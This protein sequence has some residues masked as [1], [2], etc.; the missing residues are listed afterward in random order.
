MCE[1]WV[2]RCVK[3]MRLNSLSLKVL[4]AY[5]AGTVLS[6]ALLVIAAVV[7]LQGN[8]L[9]RMDV[10]A[11]MD[12]T[13]QKNLLAQMDLADLA[14]GM[15]RRVRFDAAGPVGLEADEDSLAWVYDSLR[16]EA[17][18]RVLDDS[19]KTVLLSKAGEAFWPATDGRPHPARGR[20]DFEHDGLTIYG[21]TE[22]IE[23]G[24]RTWYLQVAASKRLMTLLHR[25]ALPLVGTGITLFSLVLL[26]TFG[27]CAYITLRYTLKPLR[28]VS[29]SAAAISPRSMHARLKTEG[30]PLEIA[31]L[32]DSFNRALARLE[33]GYR[34]QQEF[35]GNAAHEL[36]TPLALIRAQ[37]E[38]G[39]V[40]KDRDALLSD[41]E[42]MT[43]QVQQLLLLAEA[44]EA[45]NY[46]FTRVRMQEIADEAVTYL[47]RM[48]EAADVRLIVSGV[49]SD[50]SWK[51]DR[52][53]LFTLLKNLL[54]NAIQHAP[55]QTVVSVGIGRDELSVWDL[56]PGVDAAQLPLL[57]ERFW[58]GAHRR[59]RGAGLG[60]A[61]CQEIALTHGWRLSAERAEPG[62]RFRLQRGEDGQA[63]PLR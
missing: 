7:M 45:H 49:A 25:V 39:D 60:L 36:K 8:L 56:G 6:I 46:D 5:I 17:A 16:Q 14:K 61:I 57:F 30:V 11:R 48:A 19:G 62:L 12:L 58:R 63:A 18:Y 51:A 43:R 3:K 35:L 33:R 59:D 34:V 24:G 44:S 37:I 15:A 2:T 41:V 27:F 52:G 22:P 26:V 38:L 32:V 1:A 4:L 21:A 10:L 54:E 20:Y 55:A 23:H 31:P 47:Q 42:Y 9:G 53:A 29:E 50:V 28:D 40:G 13:L